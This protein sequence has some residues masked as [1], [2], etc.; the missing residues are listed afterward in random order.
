MIKKN[1]QH[2]FFLDYLLFSLAP[3]I[4]IGNAAINIVCFLIFLSFVLNVIFKQKILKN[5]KVFIKFFIFLI[6][7]LIINIILS[8]DLILS[9]K[10]T[11][12]IFRYIVIF[13]SIL[14]CLGNIK[15]F[16]KLF[17]KLIF[18]III[19]VIIDT[20]FQYFFKKDIFGFEV[21]SSHGNR[22]SGPFG[23]ELVVGSFISKL[24]FLS[25]SYLFLIKKEKYVHCFIFL[26]IVIVI[27]SNERS[28]S[29]MLV[30]STLIFYFLF[31]KSIKLKFVYIFSI[32]ILLSSMFSLNQNLKKHFITIPV[33][34]FKDNHHKAHFL[35]GIE[36]Y[37]NYKIFGSGVK[38]FREICSEEKYEN[39][40]SKY[41]RNRCASHPHNIY[42][43]ILSDTGLT[44]FLLFIS[45]NLMLFYLFLK[46]FITNKFDKFDCIKF[47]YFVILFFPLQTTG[48][49]FSTWNGIFYWIC[50]AILFH[51][52]KRRA[53]NFIK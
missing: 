52:F 27:L 51:S 24:F 5:Y 26:S 6:S 41:Y 33:K 4:I 42:I 49:F 30:F 53:A 23:S 28:A 32:L 39:I 9:A 19:F 34:H 31:I 40:D 38:T 35:T 48:S 22:L 14:Y 17:L 3:A 1:L 18:I 21:T 10:A 36:I 16:E 8:K 50:Y 13:L 7:L 29:I 45:I 2:H 20:Y 43:E 37:K 11:L 12:G 47:S 44:G 15:N 46:K 25:L